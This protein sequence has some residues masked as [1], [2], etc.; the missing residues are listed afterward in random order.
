[1]FEDFGQE[2]H[3]RSPWFSFEPSKEPKKIMKTGAKTSES[4][5]AAEA[6][7]KEATTVAQIPPAKTQRLK[8]HPAKPGHQQAKTIDGHVQDLP[9]NKD[10]DKIQRQA[11]VLR[12]LEEFNHDIKRLEQHKLKVLNG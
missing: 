9:S 8:F 10:E 11:M 6:A 4:S 7:T 5:K 12:K 1:M 2:Q 3:W